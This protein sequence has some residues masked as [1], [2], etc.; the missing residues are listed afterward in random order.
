MEVLWLALLAVAVLAGA[1]YLI[2]LRVHPWTACWRC[3]GSGKKR[4]RIWRKAHGS[5]RACGG[6][7]RHPRLGI[8]ALDPARAHSMTA[9]KGTHK[10]TDKRKGR[11]A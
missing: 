9:P 5:C 4:D 6:K 8:R 2:S 10:R 3:K 1:A 7:G 11:L